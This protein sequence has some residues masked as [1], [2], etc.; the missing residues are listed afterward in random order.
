MTQLED[1]TRDAIRRWAE[2]IEVDVPASRGSSTYVRSTPARH[3]TRRFALAI[4]AAV[5][6]V[7]VIAGAALVE[8]REHTSEPNP[9]L[10]N[11]APSVAPGSVEGM[12]SVN[13][14]SDF[15][16]RGT[17]N[18]SYEVALQR[19][20]GSCMT[21]HG[22]QYPLAGYDPQQGETTDPNQLLQ[23]RKSYGYGLLTPAQGDT[24]LPQ[25]HG[26]MIQALSPPERERFNNDLGRSAYDEGG[27]P[28]REGSGCTGDAESALHSHFPLNNPDLLAALN[29]QSQSVTKDPLYTTALDMWRTCMSGAGYQYET[30]YDGRRE[31]S[32][33]YSSSGG[34]PTEEERATERA[35][36][37]ADATCASQTL[38][39]ARSQLENTIISQ[40]VEEYGVE[41]TCGADC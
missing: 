12:R 8:S 29:G 21:A 34:S 27:A 17:G 7:L 16:T 35:I 19:R 31:V 28:V 39:P 11:P 36:G 25:Q 6:V 37:T 5:G 2:S 40:L 26:A 24:T 23:F 1:Q 4:A 41:P 33:I 18:E 38:W 10:Q 30:E 15:V 32:A 14:L 20:I 9:S 22:W 13:P 3:P